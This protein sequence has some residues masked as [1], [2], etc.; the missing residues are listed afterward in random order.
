[1]MVQI[2]QEP[3]QFY[4]LT[5]EDIQRI[6][7]ETIDAYAKEHHVLPSVIYF[8]TSYLYTF[9]LDDWELIK[10]F[11]HT[12]NDTIY[13]DE[14]GVWRSPMAV[15]W[16]RILERWCG[17][18]T[19]RLFDKPIKPEKICSTA[20]RVP[21]EGMINIANSFTGRDFN[22]MKWHAIGTGASAGT[23]PSP[24]ATQ[25]VSQQSRIDVTDDPNG[26]SLS[27][28]GSTVFVVGNHPLSTADGEYTE[29]GIFDAEH[30]DHDNMGD[31]SIFPDEVE[32][33][34][35]QN[36]IGSTTVI[37]QCST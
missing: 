21:N 28:E 30:T 37:Y 33:T 29:T 11:T 2:L 24:S 1:M 26:G 3:V 19:V 25:L 36:A 35:N 34:S 12:I 17:G 14:N 7:Q 20:D 18:Q 6:F 32:H 16:H 15:E 8:D 27:T 13:K 9:H 31:Y 23:R 4:S 10:R 5:V 22:M